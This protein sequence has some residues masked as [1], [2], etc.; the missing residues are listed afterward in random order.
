M[1]EYDAIVVGSGP[2]GLSAAV[3]IASAGCKVLV[4]E[5]KDTIGGGMRTLEL[6]LP[7]FKHDVCS[8]IH[9]MGIASP[10]FSK[11]PLEDYGLEWIFPDAETAHPLDNGDA[12]IVERSVAK[13][14]AQFGKDEATYKRIIQPLVD[15]YPKILNDILAPLKIPRYP[16]SFAGFGAM[17]IL[18]ST[19]YTKA[20]F[21]DER[22]RAML[23]GM[24]AHAIRPM[25]SL[26][27][28]AVGLVLLI[29]AHGVGWGYPKGGSQKIAD[30]LAAHLKTMRGEIITGQHVKSLDELP[31]AR[32]IIFNTT[33]RQM[34]QIAG[35]ALPSH[36]RKQ[37]EKFRYGSG[38]FKI[39]YALS[40]P[41]PWA[42]ENVNRAATV[43]VVG[44]FDEC[45]RAEHQST[46]NQHPDQ[47]YVLVAQ[48][49]LF[50]DTRAPEGK[51]TGWAYC[52]V[53]NGSTKD[54]TEQ[55]EAQI[56]RFAPNFKDVILERHTMH[57]M[58][59]QS[60]NPNYIGGDI[61]GGVQDVRQLFTRPVPRLNP[62]TTPNPSLFIGSSS[63]PPG[64]GVHGMNGY[65]A[66]QAVLKQLL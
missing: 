60:Y 32:A 62:Y 11:L 38:V 1:A 35:D 4:V 55:I 45:V 17:G 7:D 12:V 63:T 30:A 33:P 27:T 58:D 6:T 47:P 51:H 54:M 44:S 42:N 64:G 46:H 28:T 14:A 61:N 25:D 48:Q 31:P 3:E 13:T 2:N 5:A 53:P 49:S 40:D 43:H 50:D 65:H 23:G 21:R 57:A 37:L 18:P 66:A 22:T 29:L 34:L 8:A 9:P 10:M 36:Y 41:I 19:L 20:L 52:H 56:S 16:I 26:A 15:N 39:D 59:M 24:I